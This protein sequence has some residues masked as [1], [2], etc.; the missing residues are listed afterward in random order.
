[1][2]LRMGLGIFTIVIGIFVL[3]TGKKI[4][5]TYRKYKCIEKGCVWP[6]EDFGLLCRDH[7][8]KAARRA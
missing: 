8:I 6:G 5:D 4:R 3:L 7:R 1:M 2:R